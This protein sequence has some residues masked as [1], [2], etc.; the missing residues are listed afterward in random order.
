MSH[1][2][3]VESVQQ[4]ILASNDRD[5]LIAW[6]QWNDPNGCYSDDASDL[7]D[8]PRLSVEELKAAMNKQLEN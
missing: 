4:S 8:L 1:I 7:E 3:A 2:F 6:L 5:R